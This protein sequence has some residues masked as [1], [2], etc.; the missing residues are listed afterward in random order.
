M[1]GD[2]MGMLVRHQWPG[3][4]REMKNLIER[5]VIMTG[6]G[7]PSIELGDIPD[8]IGRPATGSHPPQA[9]SSLNMAPAVVVPQDPQQG[10]PDDGSRSLKEFK[11]DVERERILGALEANDWNV[12]R[13]A[14]ALGIE[15]TNLHKKIKAHG[16]VRR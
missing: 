4:I 8:Y 6:P 15:R 10:S 7:K 1:S 16:L 5:L 12:S 2:A 9:A 3:N 14:A 13:T 11:S